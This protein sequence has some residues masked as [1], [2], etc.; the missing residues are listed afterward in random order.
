MTNEDDRD[1]DCSCHSVFWWSASTVACN[2]NICKVLIIMGILFNNLNSL[3][4]HTTFPVPKNYTLF[5]INS[6]YEQHSE[7]A[8]VWCAVSVPAYLQADKAAGTCRSQPTLIY[9]RR[10]K[11]IQLS[12]HSPHVPFM[13][14][15]GCYLALGLSALRLQ[16]CFTWNRF[17]VA[18]SMFA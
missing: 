13:A 2:K 3:Q 10:Y 5:Q 17:V 1:L 16:R 4:L 15:M 14:V 12:C 11:W 9:N 6:C 18:G 8:H 7:W